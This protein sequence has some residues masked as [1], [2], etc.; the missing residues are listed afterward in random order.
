MPSKINTC[1]QFTWD[2]AHFVCMCVCVGGGVY[3]PHPPPQLLM[4]VMHVYI[5][6]CMW[7]VVQTSVY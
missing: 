7:T 4:P 3:S 5:H 6:V 1:L 2:Y